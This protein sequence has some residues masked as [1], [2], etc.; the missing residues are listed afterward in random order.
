MTVYSVPLVPILANTPGANFGMEMMMKSTFNIIDKD[1]KRYGT[2]EF[3]IETF[4]GLKIITFDRPRGNV[5]Q[6]FKS[7]RQYP[8]FSIYQELIICEIIVD[9]QNWHE[10]I[11]IYSELS[12]DKKNVFVRNVIGSLVWMMKIRGFTWFH[13]PILL[14]GSSVKD[15]QNAKEKS[16]EIQALHHKPMSV[17]IVPWSNLNR[18]S[19]RM[20][21]MEWIQENHIKLFRL[22][23]NGEDYMAVWNILQHLTTDL[24]LEIRLISLWAAIENIVKPKAPIRQSISKRIAMIC[25][26][27]LE[28]RVGKD[29]KEIYKE[30]KELYDYRCDVVHGN[31]PLIE[32]LEG[33]LRGSLT[34]KDAKRMDGFSRTFNVFKLLLMGIIER[35]SFYEKRELDLF[36]E[37]FEK[38]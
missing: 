11:P 15:L 38:L 31:R 8:H 33:F 10:K 37:K 17:P 3:I 24:E 12:R 14:K 19:L 21:D 13:T 32:N 16:V 9:D 36:E 2:Y 28:M 23:E 25:N 7:M 30:V 6:K 35:G 34:E 20:E 1:K 27:D 18:E 22:I 4:P 29:P 26:Q 5:S